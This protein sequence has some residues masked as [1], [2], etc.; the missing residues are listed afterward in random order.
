[1]IIDRDL[2]EDI[3]NEIIEEIE[4]R[5]QEQDTINIF[6]ELERGREISFEALLKGIKYKYSNSEK[7][8]KIAIVTDSKWFQTT[9][10]LSD[11]LLDVKVRTFDI[12]D[13]LEAIQW[14]SI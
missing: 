7:F 13:R 9:V 4:T 2:T 8:T 1:M 10:N 12:K 14:I 3:L 5:S 11:I 6:I